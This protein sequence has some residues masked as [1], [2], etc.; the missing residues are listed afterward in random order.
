MNNAINFE[1]F[2]NYSPTGKFINDPRFRGKKIITSL[3]RLDEKYKGI[4][5]TIKAMKL[6]LEKDKSYCLIVG[7]D[8]KLRNFYEKCVKKFGLEKNIYFLGK[9]TDNEVLELY[10]S[11]L[12]FV[13]PS[14]YEGFGYVFIESVAT[15]V[16]CIHGNSDGSCEALL[17]GKYGYPFDTFN[18]HGIAEKILETSKK[19]IVNPGELKNYY[20]L[21]KFKNNFWKI[22]EARPKKKFI[23]INSH[24]VNYHIQIYRK[25]YQFPNIHS[26]VYFLLD[27][28]KKKPLEKDWPMKFKEEKEYLL[29]GYDFKFVSNL[30]I[31]KENT[32]LGCLN[33]SIIYHIFKSKPDYIL[34]FGWNNLIPLFV[35]FT[36]IF[37]RSKLVIRGESDNIGSKHDLKYFFK[38]KYLSFL[39]KFF[40]NFTYSYEKNK[41]YFLERGVSQ[42]NLISFPCSV[43]NERYK[44]IYSNLPKKSI[45]IEGLNLQHFKKIFLF[46]G[47]LD[48][49][50]RILSLVNTFIKIDNKD[51]ALLIIGDG[52]QKDNLINKIKN[53]ENIL[54]FGFKDI[55]DTTKFYKLS[56]Y[57]ILNSLKDPSPKTVNEAMN[58]KTIPLISSNCG[59]AND[60]IVDGINGFTFDTFN[61]RELIN[62]INKLSKLSNQEVR[63]IQQNIDKTLD[64]WNVNTGIDNLRQFI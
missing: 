25:I 53:I 39:F 6:V 64:N 40:N 62:K 31:K 3:S 43:D 30:S 54:Y 15:G 27:P 4:L 47:R 33:I 41:K 61:E 12:L 35:L 2:E 8:G 22:I 19:D 51:I 44:L 58:F 14:R 1:K 48:E 55:L 57:L 45:L 23:I 20:T 56:D 10:H 24:P 60:M 28:F 59:T 7:G 32:L 9:L 18:K 52:S 11:G 26:E 34:L 13:L 63:E 46:C 38:K 37:L 29:S 50:K 42:K 21:E 36:K 49:R 16:N 17:D 5:T